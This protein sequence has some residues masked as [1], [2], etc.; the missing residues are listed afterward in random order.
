VRYGLWPPC[1]TA[2]THICR[3]LLTGVSHRFPP[4]NATNGKGKEGRGIGSHTDYGLLVIA[5]QD[6]VGGE[7]HSETRHVLI[8]LSD[9]MLSGLFIRRPHQE[10]KFANWET[11]AAGLRENDDKWVYIPPVDGVH[12][13]ILGQCIHGPL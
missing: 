6:D 10:E 11:S 9:N 1:R 12:T 5:A 4:R 8:H 13:V 2:S 3:R 7:A